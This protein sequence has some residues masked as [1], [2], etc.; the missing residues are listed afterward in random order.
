V[1]PEA[2]QLPGGTSLGASPS[3]PGGTSADLEQ[4]HGEQLQ[5]SPQ[6]Q[7]VLE[8]ISISDRKWRS[9]ERKAYVFSVEVLHAQAVS[10]L[11][12]QP[13]K[14]PSEQGLHGHPRVSL[15][16]GSTTSGH[17]QD[18]HSISPQSWRELARHSQAFRVFNGIVRG[19]G[20]SG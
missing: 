11:Q 13:A 17:P 16:T 5:L 1:R 19:L 2:Q 4:L 10:L 3:G 18:C 14:F 9:G 8:R 15:V 7:A 6:T 12:E 20:A